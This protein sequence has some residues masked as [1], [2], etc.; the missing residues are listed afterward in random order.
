MGRLRVWNALRKIKPD[1]TPRGEVLIEE[2]FLKEAA[3]SREALLEELEA[4]LIT[5]PI[6]YRSKV[7]WQ[8]WCRQGYFTFALI[9]GPFNTLVES[10]GWTRAAQWIVRNPAATRNFMAEYL[11]IARDYAAHAL[12]EGCEGLILG[13]DLAGQNGLLV[14]P[15]F[16]RKYY[17]PE[18]RCWLKKIPVNSTPI[19]FHGDGDVLDIITDLS[20][21]GFWGLQG[22]QP[23]ANMTMPNLPAELLHDWVWWGNMQFEGKLGLKDQTQLQ[24]EAAQL[25]R[26]WREVPGYILGSSGGLYPSLPVDLVRAAYRL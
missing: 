17:F 3:I 24:T 6:N 19:L 9:N 15:A 10:L 16:L 25:C 8:Y 4:D 5:L 22:L 21:I 26:Q 23:D 13:D 18:L 11:K 7:D 14:D 1:R 12:D 20:N 2:G